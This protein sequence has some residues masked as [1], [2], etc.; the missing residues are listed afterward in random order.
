MK[1]LLV[2]LKELTGNNITVPSLGLW[3]L[4]STVK[5]LDPNSD[6]L[7][8]DENIGDDMSTY[9]KDKFDYI[10]I[11]AMFSTQHFQYL[12]AAALAKENGAIVFG[13][14]IHSNIIREMTNQLN[15]IDKVC[16]G[17]GEEFIANN[18]FN[19]SFGS[20]N[21]YPNPMFE[22]NE[23]DRYWAENKPFG[24]E[25]KTKRW[26]PFETS[27][28]CN[29][30]CDFCIVP[31]YWG[32]WRKF[33]LEIVENRMRF[34]KDRGVEEVFISDDNMSVDS[35]HFKELMKLFKKYGFY[36]STPNGFSAKTLTNDECF[37]ALV[38]TN[39][40]RL[41]IAFDAT[42]RKSAELIDMKTKFVEY[43][44][45]QKITQKLKSANISSTGF[46]II[47]YPGQ[48]IQDIKDTLEFANS[49]PLDNRHIHIAT[50]YPGTELYKL[51]IQ[52]GY[53]DCEEKE[54]FS[55]LI[56][57]K[58]YQKSLI[59]TED[60]TPEQVEQIRKEDREKAIVKRNKDV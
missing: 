20:L 17:D 11:S 56:N 19:T 60:F 47:G 2:K 51:C 6:V 25:S 4:R 43:E 52:K 13:G 27:R 54:I 12:K 37:D 5:A 29:R 50:P 48:T 35:S 33:D 45:A 42:S 41:Q 8:C 32:K 34:L 9:L 3:A 21:N 38:E 36:W 14:G 18:I 22:T 23:M 16:I 30:S 1:I 15:L 59:K 10:G 40:W 49:L 55:R 44:E 26:V 24:L 7:I 46:F 31:S 28:G 53:L 39:C 58:Q 57:N